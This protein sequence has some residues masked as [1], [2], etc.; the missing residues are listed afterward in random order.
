MMRPPPEEC[1]VLGRSEYVDVSPK[2][3]STVRT[4][5]FRFSSIMLVET[6]SGAKGWVCPGA[7]QVRMISW[8]VGDE[9]LILLGGKFDDK[10][11]LANSVG[12]FGAA[13]GDNCFR[14]SRRRH[15][16]GL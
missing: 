1:P 6:T 4:R 12:V 11:R 15:P 2:G 13:R 16:P 10:N 14:L 3:V 8:S 9:G 7:L 5:L